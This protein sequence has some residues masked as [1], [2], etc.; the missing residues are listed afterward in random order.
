MVGVGAYIFDLDG[1]IVDSMPMHTEAWLIYLRRLGIP[2]DRL[3]ERMHGRRNDEIVRDLFGGALPAAEIDAHGAAKER[4]YRELMA[5]RLSACLVPGIAAFLDRHPH[6]PKGVASNAEPANVDFVLEGA[7]L[8]AHFPVRLNG[9]HATRPKP[10]PEIY[11]RAA[12]LLNTPPAECVIFEDSPA[13]MAA[14]HGS[15]ARVVA[16]NTARVKL[17]RADLEI[18]DFLDPGLEPWLRTIRS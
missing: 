4:L 11:R 6:V 15:G 7:G 16:V 13:G 3:V 17:P 10:D 18:D 2:S 8:G 9:R 5:P 12:A 1:V 14:A